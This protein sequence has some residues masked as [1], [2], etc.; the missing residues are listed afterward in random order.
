MDHVEGIIKNKFH[1]RTSPRKNRCPLSIYGRGVFKVGGGTCNKRG[2]LKL[3]VCAYFLVFFL[4]VSCLTT[5]SFDRSF[6]RYEP[7]LEDAGEQPCVPSWHVERCPFEGSWGKSVMGCPPSSSFVVVFISH[8]L[9]HNDTPQ[10]ANCSK[11]S[12][13]GRK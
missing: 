13:C 1:A 8:L 5:I 9:A 4:E 7:F 12:H 10:T 3:P 11:A 6:K 2:G